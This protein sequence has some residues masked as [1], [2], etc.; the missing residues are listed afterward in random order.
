M[1]F[2]TPDPEW[3]Y[4]RLEIQDSDG[5]ILHESPSLMVNADR[6]IEVLPVAEPS[7]AFIHEGE[8]FHLGQAPPHWFGAFTNSGAQINARPAQTESGYGGFFRSQMGDRFSY[9]ALPY[10]LYQA[11]QLI[12]AGEVPTYAFNSGLTSQAPPLNVP[13][14]S[15]GPYILS[16]T[17]DQYWVYD[18]PGEA[19]VIAEFDTTRED[20]DPPVL[21]SLTVLHDD[22]TTDI[23]PPL[24][25]SEIRFRVQDSG[26]LSQVSLFY[27]DAGS[28][29]E[30][31]LT[32]V[33]DEYVADLPE[34]GIGEYVQ[35]A[36]A[37]GDTAGNSLKYSV[38]PAFKVADPTGA[39]FTANPTSGVVPLTVAFANSSGGDYADS[40]WD[41]GDGVTS[42]QHSPT[43]TY[44]L[45]GVFSV[46]LSVSGLDGED[47]LTRA[48]YI[49]VY[50]AVQADFTASP[51]SGVAPLTVDFHNL[52]AGDFDS[53]TWTFGDGAS[54]S[55]CADPSHEYTSGGVYAV[56]LACSGLGGT[57]TM[58]RS[59]YITVYEPAQA[60]FSASQ[61]EGIAPVTILYEN[62]SS[63]DFA[64][65]VWAFGDGEGS[66]ACSDPSHEYSAPGSY[67]VTLT[68]S[69]LGGTD[70][71]TRSNYITTYDPVH[72]D[73]A[74]S[75]T[76]G[77]AP[78]A[79][80]F[81]N[82]SS[83]D[84][85]SCSWTFGDGA[86][87][88]ECADP[89]HEYT[90]GGVYAVTLACSGLGGT[91]TMTRSDYI[92]VYEP[93]QASFSASQTEGIA[94]VTVLFENS[95]SG[96]FAACVWTFGDG[97]GSAEC[98]D[99]SHAYA[100]PGSY[101]VTLTVS[102]LGGTDTLT[103][104]DYITVYEQ[105]RADFSA[106]PA[107]G[108][109]PLAV[110]FSNTSSGDYDNSLWNFGDGVT[111]T[112]HSPTHV[113]SAVGTYTV[114]LSID[115]SGGTDTETKPAYISVEPYKVYLPRVTRHGGDAR[116]QPGRSLHRQVGTRKRRSD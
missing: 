44:S 55:E 94:P 13:L 65:C 93:V 56:T 11:G 116:H 69:G 88:S 80:D 19:R 105:A 66:G 64:A 60:S 1:P 8:E 61:T 36:I 103:R 106:S 59:D 7:L 5:W 95:S 40:T 114:T 28:W 24:G 27:R 30:L 84:F 46:T 12:Q 38:L 17:Y 85:D 37:A 98:S 34:L 113:Y 41:F 45:S 70:T 14:P 32:N 109:P 68:V 102:G 73:F 53:C 10:E 29:A 75:P 72:A 112:L 74:A 51:T 20:K 6:D 52:S 89:S 2:D 15:P 104:S 76:S 25:A 18:Q 43:H 108:T 3:G 83:G 78:L 111:S 115:G 57:D 22:E 58:T 67:T 9:N 50:D 99:P 92:T 39:Y 96:D 77:V 90:S 33:A 71:L 35:L 81:D 48:N 4:D 86:S 49:G 91:D 97:E 31:P 107:V 87:S 23:V 47:A 100:A 21:L 62:S 82:L 26:G 63:G 101:T 16:L 54:S 42:T 110:Q 79:I